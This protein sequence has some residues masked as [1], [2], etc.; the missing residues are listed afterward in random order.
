[1][2]DL[3]RDFARLAVSDRS[4]IARARTSNGRIAAQKHTQGGKVTPAFVTAIGPLPDHENSW[5]RLSDSLWDALTA[6]SLQ[7]ALP[8]LVQ[9]C[10]AAQLD[11]GSA[12]IGE[13]EGISMKREP[14]RTAAELMFV[15][16]TAYQLHRLSADWHDQH[17][18]HQHSIRRYDETSRWLE[19]F[20]PLTS[21]QGVSLTCLS[22]TQAL[23][24]EKEAMRH[25]VDGYTYVCMF[26]RTHIVSLRGPNNSWRTTLELIPRSGDTVKIG[27]HEGPKFH[28]TLPDAAIKTASWIVESINSGTIPVDWAAINQNHSKNIAMLK[29]HR[30][31]AVMLQVNFDPESAADADNAYL[32]WHKLAPQVFRESTRTAFL[33][34]VRLSD[35]VEQFIANKRS[36]SGSAPRPR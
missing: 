4:V 7:I 6:A 5:F 31:K 8:A 16:S 32:R 35:Y 19:L 11:W 15:N 34:R 36:T 17:D 29:A 14:F 28:N 9:G 33:Q 3:I 23:Q 25:C 21:P 13:Q 26:E 18:R 24:A 22:S 27:Q 20:P 30:K 2:P 10:M 1:V 12:L